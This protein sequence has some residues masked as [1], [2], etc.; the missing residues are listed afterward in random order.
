MADENLSAI[1]DESK[2]MLE[3]HVKKGKARKFILITKGATIKSLIVFKKGP[4]GPKINK[5]KKDGFRGEATCGV[6]TGK[7]VNISF[8]LPGTAEVSSAMK[9]E[10]NVYEGEPCKIAKLRAFFKDEADLKFKPEFQIVKSIS[11]VT[12]VSEL[13]D[14]TE[15]NLGEVAAGDLELEERKQ[16]LVEALKRLTAVI[17]QAVAA[18]PAR[19]NEILAP[20]AGIKEHLQAGRLDEAKQG[21]LTYNEFLKEILG[22]SSPPIGSAPPPP[23]PA[24]ESPASAKESEWNW[25]LK[26]LTPQLKEVLGK[27]LGDFAQ[28]GALF[29]QAQAAKPT[30]I[31]QAV[32]LLKQCAAVVKL[33]LSEAEGEWTEATAS[34]YEQAWND[35][36]AEFEQ[37]RNRIAGAGSTEA[38]ERFETLINEAKTLAGR[39]EFQ[40]AL[41]RAMQA[42]EIDATTRSA[43]SAAEAKEIISKARQRWDEGI[44]IASAELKK[45]QDGVRDEDPELA[46]ALTDVLA[47]YQRELDELL[48]AGQM[49]VTDSDAGDQL[50][51]VLEKA[52]SLQSE[53]ANDDLIAFLDT[54]QDASVRLQDTIDE[55]LG[56]VQEQLVAT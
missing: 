42:A 27:K 30:N 4:Y 12:V 10:G 22:K 40:Q 43:A 50:K 15:E 26:E 19:K 11:D 35:A 13:D 47:G 29:K 31:E 51:S 49:V 2:A 9:T 48:A 3:D 14:E 44:K 25:R 7:G 18:Q 56:R 21:L 28:A 53:V 34:D 39:G 16:K 8:Q 32:E 1:D 55:A 20:V 17:Q 41:Q 38:L 24:P 52:K 6:I 37:Q 45:V 33:A 5:A 36:S 54:F 23:P 46:D